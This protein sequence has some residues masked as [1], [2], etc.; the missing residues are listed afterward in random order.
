MPQL[1]IQLTEETHQFLLAQ[2]ASG[3]FHTADEIVEKALSILED[4][5]DDDE[6]KLALLHA[7]ARRGFEEAEG[8]NAIVLE[9]DE[10]LTAYMDKVFRESI[11]EEY[12]GRK[13]HVNT[14]A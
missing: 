1:T 7:A 3:E 10:D 13:P 14:A 11:G 4:V 12:D 6:A 2:M 9:T 5:Q 8:P